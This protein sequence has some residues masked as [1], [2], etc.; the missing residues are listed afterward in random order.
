MKRE[1]SAALI[2]AVAALAGYA[3]W[4]TRHDFDA[5]MRAATANPAALA[6]LQALALPDPAGRTIAM[7]QWR[8]KVVVVN[9]WATWCP[10]CR[11]EM[12]LLD[13][14]QQKWAGRGVQVVGIGIDDA[15]AIREYA[16]ANTFSIPL[17]AAGPEL[18]GLTEQLGNTEQG[19]PFSVIIGR[20][21]QLKQ[22]KLGAFKEDMLDHMIE[23]LL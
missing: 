7:Q 21:G 18:I 15:A 1:V 4:H 16:A 20:D 17:L 19:L 12:P 6:R 8:G 22:T 14:A 5:P 11:R 3:G 13:A 9:F 23:S 2:I 10:P